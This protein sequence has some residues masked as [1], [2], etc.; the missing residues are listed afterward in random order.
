[1]AIPTLTANSP[2]N[3]SVAWSAF[4][5]RYTPNPTTT[6]AVSYAIS[7]GST[8]NK[9]VWWRY[10]AGTPLLQSGNTVPADLTADDLLLFLNK[11]GTPV[12]AQATQVLEG[13]LI[14]NESILTDA[15]SANCVTSPKI[16][17]GAIDATHIKTDAIESRHVKAGQI[18]AAALQVG[19]FDNLF[20]DPTFLTPLGSTGPWRSA[21]GW[22]KQAAGARDGS[23]SLRVAANGT[24]QIQINDP[25]YVFPIDTVDDPNQTNTSFFLSTIAKSS[26]ANDGGV[27]VGARWYLAAGGYADTMIGADQ[28]GLAGSWTRYKGTVT[29][30]AT[31]L[32]VQF[33]VGTTAALASGT[34][35]FDYIGANRA[36][37]GELIVDGSIRGKHIQADSITAEHLAV[38]ALSAGF[39]L[40]GAIQ[41]GLGGMTMTGG[42]QGEI[43]IPDPNS[44]RETILSGAGSVFVG[45]GTFDGLTVLGKMTINGLTNF[46][47]GLVTLRSGVGDPLRKPTVTASHNILVINGTPNSKGYNR[48]GLAQYGNR[49][50]MT[51][52]AGIDGQIQT[53]DVFSGGWTFENRALPAGW[54]PVG[55]VTRVDGRYYTLCAASLNDGWDWQ[56]TGLRVY[57]HENDGTLVAYHALAISCAGSGASRPM[58]GQVNGTT[59][60]IIAYVNNGTLATAEYNV[61]GVLQANRT[62]STTWGNADVCGVG[63]QPVPPAAG[64]AAG[65]VRTVVASPTGIYVWDPTNNPAVRVIA[66]DWTP[67]ASNF[68]ISGIALGDDGKWYTTTGA[69]V[70]QYTQNS[71]ARDFAYDWEDTNPAGLGVART[72]I[73]PIL[74]TVPRRMAIWNVNYLEDLPSDGTTDGADSAGIYVGPTG[75]GLIRQG[76]LPAGT[77]TLALASLATS[78]TA[79]QNPSEFAGRAS[80]VNGRISS[81]AATVI[82]GATIPVI[83][84]SGTGPGRAGP[85]RWDA[86]GLS[87]DAV[88]ESSAVGGTYTPAV[89]VANAAP[90][91]IADLVFTAP[92]SGRVQIVMTMFVLSK[93]A[94]GT[95]L[96][97]PEVCAGGTLRAG[98]VIR[99]NSGFDGAANYNTAYVK[100]PAVT[101]VSGLTPG[102]AY[103]VFPRCTCTAANGATW[104]LGVVKVI[105]LV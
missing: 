22:S 30:P 49:W 92:T 54:L 77:T 105:P 68:T 78:G 6:A 104:T 102:A 17:A 35:D 62:L 2:V 40:A 90:A 1:M 16:I 95:A 66:E 26:V 29:A 100:A 52:Y 42:E 57:I 11:L 45:E 19:S 12:N 80:T 46:I 43:R 56:R 67:S 74:N 103:N 9:F 76:I 96:F 25:D 97:W 47:N 94:G 20:A 70:T 53:W 10:N 44:D 69:A 87:I 79:P 8:A 88:Q 3:G 55:G 89:A 82:S 73:S 34:V 65:S 63:R 32:A 13:S 33:F 5:I 21:T 14:V 27:V 4:T 24:S 83:D 48:R 37:V 84:L 64:G 51:D 7:A 18:T 85:S 23:E 59:N 39:V 60:Y 41:I 101:V 99:S 36:G 71:G 58:I 50:V 98:T 15:L 75:G 38:D 61:S 93:T 91:G 72:K 81:G 28:A 86:A 31:A